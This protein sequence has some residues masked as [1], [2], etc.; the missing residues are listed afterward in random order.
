[1]KKLIS[2]FTLFLLVAGAVFAQASKD[3]VYYLKNGSIIKGHVIDTRK[4]GNL[5]IETSDG[6]VVLFKKS[7]ISREEEDWD[8]NVLLFDS[9]ETLGYRGFVEIGLVPAVPSFSIYTSH[10]YQ[11]NKNFFAGLGAGFDFISENHNNSFTG[12]SIFGNLRGEMTDRQLAPYAD[13]KAGFGLSKLNGFLGEFTVGG[14]YAIETESIPLALYVGLGYSIKGGDTTELYE[15]KTTVR[16]YRK[17]YNGLIL[18]AGI[19]F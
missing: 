16:K 9:S 15:D 6:N 18:K 4:D 12:F 13:I 8:K 17:S 1:M 10:G 14:R 3:K 2:I 11:I 7:D 19:E 5:V